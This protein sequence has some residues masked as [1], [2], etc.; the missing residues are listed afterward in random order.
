MMAF[1][2]RLPGLREVVERLGSVVRT[3]NFSSLGP[4][5]NRACSLRLVQEFLGRFQTRH[6]PGAGEL[7][8]LDSMAL[9]LPATRRNRCKKMNDKTVG[10][11]VLWAFMINAAHG[12]C[13]VQVLK[14]MQGAWNDSHQMKGIELIA[15]GPVYLM[16]RGFFALQLIQSW[17]DCHVRFIVR[18]KMQVGVER[19]RTLSHA[20]AYRNGR[21]VSDAWV[22]LGGLQAKFHP[23]VRMIEARLGKMT[24]RVVTGEMKWSAEQ[25]LDAYKK[26]DRIERFHRFI[27]ESVG[28]AHLYSFAHSGMMFLLHTAL[29]VALLLFLGAAGV[30]GTDT[31]A[32]LR[33]LLKSL[34]ASL[35][36]FG[37]WKR[38]I[39][40]ASRDKKQA[41]NL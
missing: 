27:K 21:I 7:V 32:L 18:A 41:T 22:R 3:N 31:A 26:R 40:P 10:G 11:G 39:R 5:L 12:C 4:A 13:P 24:L 19:L 14:V 23:E 29:L 37:L 36:L 38:N 30:K 20:R 8:A 16:D 25:I 2:L 28:L 33:K 6:K 34:R 35:G 9:A 1:V 15:R 17:Q